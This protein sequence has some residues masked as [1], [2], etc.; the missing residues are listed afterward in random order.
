VTQLSF[1][2][3]AAS[4]PG[5]DDLAGLLAGPGQA[6]LRDGRARVSVVVAEDWRVEALQVALTA[7]GLAPE[8]VATQ[9]GATSV[10]TPFSA[11]LLPLVREWH[12][13]G[14]KR[15]PSGLVLDGPRLRW[16]C[17][18][19]GR[20]DRAEG[21]G[22]LLG[23]G[24]SDVDEEPARAPLARALAAAG[25]PAAYLGPRGGGPAYR[26]S[27]RR[28]L[29]RLRELVGEPPPGSEPGGWPG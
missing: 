9:A 16:W 20:A 24:A 28:R 5:V 3:A 1:F 18:A 4:E 22:H 29:A 17:L 26:V 21:A 10:R 27:G 23:L 13:R 19:G 25:L 12:P 11:D 14:R 15:P 7:L 6:V 2:A 8:A